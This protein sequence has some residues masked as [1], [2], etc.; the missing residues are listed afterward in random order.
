VFIQ[1]FG[2]YFSHNPM[3]DTNEEGKQINTILISSTERSPLI[4]LF[5]LFAYNV[6]VEEIEEEVELEEEKLK[7][8]IETGDS[9]KVKQVLDDATIKAVE[10]AG[11]DINYHWEN[12]KLLMMFISC[13]FAMI[14]QFYPIPFP[15]SR[16]LLAICCAMYFIISTVLQGIVTFVDKDTILFTKAKEVGF[17][18]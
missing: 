16:P 13:V 12:M 4:L 11:F 6:V 8:I 7:T 9:V 2:S 3:S 14:A 18:Y 5:L 1:S 15:E 17:A 10:L